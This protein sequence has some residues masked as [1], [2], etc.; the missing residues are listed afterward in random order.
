M[1]GNDFRSIES[2]SIIWGTHSFFHL[3]TQGLEL[4]GRGRV[5]DPRSRPGGLGFRSFGRRR[6][7]RLDQLMAKPHDLVGADVATDHAVG[8][9]RLKWLIH[10]TS[11]GV[12]YGSHRVRNSAS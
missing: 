8:Q 6:D 11:A 7:E 10:N 5:H 9:T 3:D 2:C 12:E 1:T 4:T